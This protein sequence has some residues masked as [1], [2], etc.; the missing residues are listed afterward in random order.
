MNKQKKHEGKF[1]KKKNI[2]T[3]DIVLKINNNTSVC[4]SWLFLFAKACFYILY[5]FTIKLYIIMKLC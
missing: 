5:V 1:K 4:I 2:N 3:S